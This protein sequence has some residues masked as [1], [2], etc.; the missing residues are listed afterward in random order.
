V[1][2]SFASTGWVK[3]E[4]EAV[5]SVSKSKKEANRCSHSNLVV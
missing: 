2:V 1:T 5:A 3:I 4:I